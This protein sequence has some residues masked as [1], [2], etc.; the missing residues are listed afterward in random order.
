M[1]PLLYCVVNRKLYRERKLIDS[2]LEMSRVVEGSNMTANEHRILC[3]VGNVLKLFAV[4][5]A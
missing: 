2:G 3:T 4:I 1:T 5:D